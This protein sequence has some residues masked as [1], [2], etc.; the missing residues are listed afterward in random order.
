MH[1]KPLIT[2]GKKTL[3]VILVMFY[4]MKMITFCLTRDL[5]NSKGYPSTR[6]PQLGMQRVTLDYKTTKL[7]LKLPLRIN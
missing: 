4:V 5:S 6:F 3:N 7:H 2:H 1:L